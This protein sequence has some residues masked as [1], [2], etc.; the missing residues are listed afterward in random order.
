MCADEVFDEDRSNLV[1][2]PINRQRWIYSCCKQLLDRVI[3]AYGQRARAAV[4]AVPA[5]QLDRPAARQPGFGAHRQLARDHAVHPEP[6]RGLADPARRR[7]RAAALLHRRAR[8]HRVP[9][10][11]S[12]RTRTGAATGGSSTSATRDNDLSIRELAELPRPAVRAPIPLRGRFPPFA[13][14]RE[15]ESA[16]YYG[17][18]YQDV[19]F[20]RPSIANARRLLGWEPRIGLDEAVAGTLDYFLRDFVATPAAGDELRPSRAPRA[21][22]ASPASRRSSRDDRERRGLARPSPDSWDCGSTSTPSAARGCGVPALVPPARRAR[23]ARHLLLLRRARQHGP[24][25][26]APAAPGVPAQ[27]APQPRR[28]PLRLGHPAA[29]HAVAGPGI[30]ERLADDIRAAADAGHE[31]G[32][33]A[34]DHHAWQAH[35]EALCRRAHRGR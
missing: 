29:R 34:W 18:G 7:R 1:L 35:L 25:P 5:V 19:Q 24:A 22:G 9:V 26:A 4:H 27:D 2:G 30:G 17:E 13:G 8:R 6:G 12:S 20:R 33:H 11:A 14:F 21:A 10:A 28:E 15:V 32:L 31:I 23:P 16:A 3:W